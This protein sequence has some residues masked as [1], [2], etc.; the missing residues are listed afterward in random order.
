[1]FSGVFV[2][3]NVYKKDRGPFSRVSW[4][5]DNRPNC[6]FGLIFQTVLL[7]VIKNSFQNRSAVPLAGHEESERP[8]HETDDKKMSQQIAIMKPILRFLQLL[9][10]NH[11]RDLQVGVLMFNFFFNFLKCFIIMFVWVCV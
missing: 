1:M 3:D 8:K 7:I 2:V 11:N 9:C 4:V 5:T 10:E 6:S